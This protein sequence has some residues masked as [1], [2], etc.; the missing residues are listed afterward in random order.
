MI[1]C[2]VAS[3]SLT[4]HLTAGRIS[5]QGVEAQSGSLSTS[6]FTELSCRYGRLWKNEKLY[7]VSWSVQY[8]GVNTNFLLYNKDGS[9]FSQTFLIFHVEYPGKRSPP[10]NIVRVDLSSVSAKKVNIK[11][12]EDLEEAELSVCC[13]VSVLEEVRYGQTRPKM[14]QKCSA[15]SVERGAR[16]TSLDSLLG[17]SSYSH[18]LVEDKLSSGAIIVGDLSGDILKHI[19]NTRP[20]DHNKLE[21]REEPVEILNVLGDFGYS[22]VGMAKT[23][24]NSVI[25]TLKKIL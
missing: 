15:F 1:N 20:L 16:H 25:W 10:N 14:K 18:I 3:L 21:V 7:S 12:S 19:R 9:E 4:L 22:V 23:P 17:H 11:V 5:L 2:L 13:K 8:S 24:H 6:E